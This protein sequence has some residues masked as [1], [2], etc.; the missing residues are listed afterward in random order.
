M[1]YELNSCQVSAKE[2]FTVD[3]F[4]PSQPAQHTFLVLHGAGKA[5]RKRMYPVCERL[6][7]AGFAAWTFD[8][9]GHGDSQV[10]LESTSLTDRC[11][12]AL[13]VLERMPENVSVLTFSMAGQTVVDMIAAGARLEQI[14]LFAPAAYD[15]DAENRNFGPDF[16]AVI[17]QPNSWAR[18]KSFEILNQFTGGVTLVWG[19]ED[20]VIPRGVVDKL[21]E[22][23]TSAVSKEL[24]VL[25][26]APHTLSGWMLS[27][28]AVADKIMEQTLSRINSV[29]KDSRPP[30]A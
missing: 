15:V 1:N 14:I 3:Q 10:Q 21:L 18:S 23:A 6:A 25:E 9:Y 11:S 30:Q 7:K 16:S 28:D 22:S 24:I 19:S 4:V 29:F 8:F 5:D 2:V 13:S 20:T 27:D 26:G 17:R 12:Q